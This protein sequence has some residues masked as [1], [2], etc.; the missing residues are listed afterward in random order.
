MATVEKVTTTNEN[1]GLMTFEQFM[2]KLRG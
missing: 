1:I 2:N